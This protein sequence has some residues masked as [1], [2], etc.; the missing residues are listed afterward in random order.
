MTNENLEGASCPLPEPITDPI[1]RIVADALTLHHVKWRRGASA[2]FF[3]PEYDT[4]IECKQFYSPRIARQMQHNV[5]VIVI[6]GK[7]A[8]HA[9]ASLLSRDNLMARSQLKATPIP[10]GTK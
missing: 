4:A 2:D 1:E 10:E 3:L 5:N 7:K 9:F 8:A 6:Q